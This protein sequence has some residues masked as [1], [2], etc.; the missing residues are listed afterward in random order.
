MWAGKDTMD[1]NMHLE[2]MKSLR[3]S[4]WKERHE[5]YPSKWIRHHGNFSVFSET[6]FN[7]T[8]TSDT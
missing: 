4:V 1:G 8:S 7:F 5:F 6:E 3:E 2:V